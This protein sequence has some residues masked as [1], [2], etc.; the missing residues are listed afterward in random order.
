MSRFA[1]H[2]LANVNAS[3]RAGLT[4]ALAAGSG[5]LGGGRIDHHHPFAAPSTA[6]TAP[7]TTSIKGFGADGGRCTQAAG[8]K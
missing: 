4:G 2:G 7:P 5:R 6:S 8:P 1:R 3:A